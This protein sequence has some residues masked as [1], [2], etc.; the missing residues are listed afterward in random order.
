MN[1]RSWA[2]KLM[3]NYERRNREYV[4]W[5]R[6]GGRARE[7]KGHTYGPWRQICQELADRFGPHV[8]ENTLRALRA[9]GLSENLY[10]LA[11]TPQKKN[12][13][14]FCIMSSAAGQDLR[15]F[16][17]DWGFNVN[18]VFYN[19]IQSK[20]TGTL[21]SLSEEDIKGWKRCP[22]NNRYY[23]LTSWPMIWQEANRS[24][25][26]MDGHLCTVRNAE[27]ER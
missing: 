27:E 23:R 14:L 12:T 6:S 26:R 17:S 9:D 11:D 16:F 2:V 20:V 24:A 19:Q 8:L 7:F 22:F 3:K 13:L 21:K 15:G 25:Q 5:L 18:H 1:Y 4:Q 10:E